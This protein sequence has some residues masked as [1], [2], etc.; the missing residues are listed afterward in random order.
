MGEWV[1]GEDLDEGEGDGTMLHRGGHAQ[2]HTHRGDGRLT[3]RGQDRD[4]SSKYLS[5]PAISVRP[6]Y[7]QN[8]LFILKIY[9][10]IHI[11]TCKDMYIFHV[12]MY[13]EKPK[14][15]NRTLY[16]SDLLYCTE[17]LLTPGSQLDLA[18]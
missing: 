9:I 18:Q 1:G 13:E 12:D 16:M 5:S 7:R 6:T 10:C 15:R 4:L 17:G 14:T 11:L 2:A 8:C 3:H